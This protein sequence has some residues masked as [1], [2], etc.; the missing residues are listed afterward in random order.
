MQIYSEKAL[1]TAT[2]LR[3]EA[4]P[5]AIARLASNGRVVPGE[6]LEMHF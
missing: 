3:E 5:V 4:L 2:P 1:K 6:F